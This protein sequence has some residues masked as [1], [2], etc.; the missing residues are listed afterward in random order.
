MFYSSSSSE[1][2]HSTAV[3]SPALDLTNFGG[4]GAEPSRIGSWSATERTN[5]LG[6][7]I[8]VVEVKVEAFDDMLA[9]FFW[10]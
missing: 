9:G 4:G 1:S 8:S 7:G 10:Y 5:L 6:P 3:P 2:D